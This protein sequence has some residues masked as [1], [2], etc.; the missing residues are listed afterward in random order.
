MSRTLKQT[1]NKQSND[2]TYLEEKYA[3]I[4]GTSLF[5]D[6]FAPPPRVESGK[7]LTASV[8]IPAWNVR[9]SILACLTAIDKSSF[10]LNHKNRFQVIVVDDGST[11]GTWEIIKKSRFSLNLTAIRQNHY[12]QAQALNTGISIAEGNIII[13][14]DA[15]MVLC[16][17]TIEHFVA[18]H[19]LSSNVLL[20]GFR[21]HTNKDNPQIDTQF[22]SQHGS[23]QSIYLTGDERIVF[24]VP[25]WPSNMC[26]ASR[27]LK[28]LGNA[29]SLWM[30]DDDAWYL[31]DLVF[32]ALFSLPKHVYFNIGGY[33]ER[34][35]GWGCSDGYLA[36]R[37]IAADQYIVPVYAASGLHIN[38]P[39]RTENKQLEYTRN[40]KLFSRLIRTCK[41]G[42]YPNWL[43]HARNRI[44]ESFTRSPIQKSFVVNKKDLTHQKVEVT[45][46]NIDCLLAIGEYS[47]AF[48]IL[49]NNPIAYNDGA[50]LLRLGKTLIGMERYQEAIGTLKKVTVP[51]NLVPESSI[52][53]AVA[54]AASGKFTSARTTLEKLSQVYPQTPDLLYWYH[55]PA[56]KHIRQGRKYFTQGFYRI[57][58]RCFEAALITDPNNRTAL[59]YRDRCLRKYTAV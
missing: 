25:G 39:P 53:L 37:A 54:Q 49:T 20:I 45:L 19:Q 31:P 16:Y 17:H 35:Y 1:L 50:K 43:A 23:P 32:G 30:P 2:Y 14:C 51:I 22:I 9:E 24:P 26:L 3:L 8:V 58:L 18:R 36:A 13:S 44:V 52:N 6:P 42:S 59:K 47:Q 57:A 7:P 11:D 40:R 10:N 29:K 33:D 28:L 46:S 48:T 55:S 56:E 21:S 27:Y 4:T 12:G 15:D 38:H 41:V 34:F 5:L